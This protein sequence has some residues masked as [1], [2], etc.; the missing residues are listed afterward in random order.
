MS[1]IYF[2]ELFSPDETGNVNNGPKTCDRIFA[3]NNASDCESKKNLFISQELNLS[4]MKFKA[5]LDTSNVPSV[6][7]VIML[8]YIDGNG[9]EVDEQLTNGKEIVSNVVV[10]NGIIKSN[11]GFVIYSSQNTNQCKYILNIEENVS[12]VFTVGKDSLGNII[13]NKTLTDNNISIVDGTYSWKFNG[14]NISSTTSNSGIT[15]S[16]IRANGNS[17]ENHLVATTPV[18][19]IVEYSYSYNTEILGMRIDTNH[20]INGT[21]VYYNA[22]PYANDVNGFTYKLFKNNQKVISDAFTQNSNDK[23]QLVSFKTSDTNNDDTI[24]V[25]DRTDYSKYYSFIE[26][27]IDEFNINTI[28]SNGFD[29]VDSS[30]NSITSTL[31]SSKAFTV[32]KKT[33]LEPQDTY[34]LQ[35]TVP[36]DRRFLSLE[37]NGDYSSN[38]KEDLFYTGSGVLQYSDHDGIKHD[39]T[40]VRAIDKIVE[41]ID[42]EQTFSAATIADLSANQ[43]LPNGITAN[44]SESNGWI[45]STGLTILNRTFIS[46]E[47]LVQVEFDYYGELINSLDAGVKFE[48]F[49]ANNILI[50]SSEIKKRSD[51]T[52]WSIKNNSIVSV[53]NGALFHDRFTINLNNYAD[54]KKMVF[55]LQGAENNFAIKDIILSIRTS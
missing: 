7:A 28:L 25:F 48:F 2:K 27:T 40:L 29:S 13:I 39:V 23:F 32:S 17:S 53:V 3:I 6:D 36:R 46:T 43:V 20:V 50:T 38:S 16:Y 42:Q 22:V 30:S 34:S 18:G 9:N 26:A 51:N 54:I 49:D 1:S 41:L 12:D 37:Y 8:H 44:L 10:E 31:D 47:N 33:T 55:T 52:S 45:K 14:I 4:T 35:Y 24:A 19:S 15:D 11:I 5:T 21:T